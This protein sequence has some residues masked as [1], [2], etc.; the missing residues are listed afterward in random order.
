MASQSANV[1]RP[2]RIPEIPE[3]PQDIGLETAAGSWV[4]VLVAGW[5][6]ALL[7][8]AGGWSLVLVAG[9]SW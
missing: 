4:V 8:G 7:A 2:G 6:Y 9:R 5:S 1:T 3:E